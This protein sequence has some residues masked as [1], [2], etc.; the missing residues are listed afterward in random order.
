MPD[1]SIR[2]NP[3]TSDKL[4]RTI[5]DD[6]DI[7]M[8]HQQ[9]RA[10]CGHLYPAW[11]RICALMDRIQDTAEHINN[12]ELHN[13]KENRSAFSFLDL[14]NY[15]SVLKDC[16]FEMARI[17]EVNIDE[18]KRSSA[19]FHQTG[20]DGQGSDKQYFEYLRSLCSVHP[21]DTGKHKR[22]QET[23]FECCPYVCWTDDTNHPDDLCFLSAYVYTNKEGEDHLKTIIISLSQVIEYIEKTYQLLDIVIIPGIE[24]FKE[25]HRDA[26]RKQI[27]KKEE[28]F[29]D[30]ISYL[31]YLKEEIRIRDNS[32]HDYYIDCV[33]RFFSVSFKNLK[34]QRR[35]AKAQNAFKLAIRYYNNA[36]QNMCFDGYENTGIWFPEEKD[37]TSLLYCLLYMRNNS[38]DARLYNYE[39]GTLHKLCDK[40]D[41]GQYAML[42]LK[43]MMPYLERYVS[44]DEATTNIE[45]YIL[46]QIALYA[47]SLRYKNNLNRNIPNDLKYRVRRLSEKGWEKLHRMKRENGYECGENLT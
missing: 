45:Y 46:S 4:R 5:N 21:I 18:Y 40:N 9:T 19:V 31:D 36:L 38:K 28:D 1:Y 23:E 7:S 15:G 26:L 16:I 8:R 32:D 24:S 3:E 29:P 13:E 2:L 14:M 27:M 6:V 35:L 33:L 25:C 10:N 42:Q 20:N 30:Y 12:L 41:S 37:E 34:N 47:D 44:F 17:Y 11:N 39:I 22:Y 43:R